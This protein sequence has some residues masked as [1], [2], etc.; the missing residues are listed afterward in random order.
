MR[1]ITTSIDG[2]LA[3]IVRWRLRL[4][5]S[6]PP[7]PA[8]PDP[9]QDPPQMPAGLDRVPPREVRLTPAGWAL[10]IVAGLLLAGGPIAG[11]LLEVKARDDGAALDALRKHGIDTIGTVVRK[12][13]ARGERRQPR[14]EYAF[15]AGDRSY[16]R[17]VDVS[18]ARWNRLEVGSPVPVRYLSSDPTASYAWGRE[19]RPLHPI[20]PYLAGI[21]LAAGGALIL[22]PLVRQKRLLAQGRAAPARVTRVVKG[23]EG[24][25]VHYEF[26]LL[27]G[28]V[29]HGKYQSSK[30]PAVGAHVWILYDP[31]RL[32]HRARYPLGLVKLAHPVRLSR[33]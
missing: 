16:R 5:R 1:P 4:H 21:G 14:V 8:L 26:R 22:T 18:L 27:S 2:R 15:P 6:D 7:E 17:S 33:D 28:A 19:P 13:R 24:K 12:W 31:D 10:A 29:A 20:L 9:R 32:G 23:H 30:P 3:A 25:D 11:V